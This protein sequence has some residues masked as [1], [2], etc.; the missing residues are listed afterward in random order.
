MELAAEMRVDGAD[1]EL[2]DRLD[3]TGGLCLI[4]AV[5]AERRAAA[6]PVDGLLPSDWPARSFVDFALD[7]IAKMTSEVHNDRPYKAEGEIIDGIEK[8]T[9]R[10]ACCGA[11]AIL[12]G[13]DPGR[14]LGVHADY[15]PLVKPVETS[16]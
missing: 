2:T 14:A 5:T 12:P 7:Q 1:E 13:T 10:W 11:L 16:K 15:C 8:A 4:R 9:K 6:K 3:A